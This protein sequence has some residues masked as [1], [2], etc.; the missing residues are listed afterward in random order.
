MG[1]NTSPNGST[2]SSA[3]ACTNSSALGSTNSSTNSSPNASADAGV[4]KKPDGTARGNVVATFFNNIQAMKEKFGASFIVVI[5]A[6]YFTQGFRSLA[7]LSMQ[8][9]LKDGLGL[10]PAASQA[11]LSTAAMPWACKPLFGLISD[12]MPIRGMKRKPSVQP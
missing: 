6:V 2:N 10:E 11:L 12:Y 1:S 7:S 3:D 4:K 9:L 8:G 5:C